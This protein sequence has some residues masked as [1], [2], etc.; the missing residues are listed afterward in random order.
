MTQFAFFDPTQDPAQVTGWYDTGNF[1]YGDNLPSLNS[2][3]QLTPEQWVSHYTNPSGWAITGGIGGSLVPYVPPA[4]SL[5]LPQQAQVLLNN[6]L[7]V[8]S[9]GTP[10]L[11]GTTIT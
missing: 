6:G 11:N 2:L 1:D 5:S 8:T 9:T 10:S 7:T 3:F 4:P